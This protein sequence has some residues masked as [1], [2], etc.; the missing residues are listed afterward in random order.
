MPLS[1]PVTLVAP[2]IW[3]YP[4]QPSKF[5]HMLYLHLRAKFDTLLTLVGFKFTSSESWASRPRFKAVRSNAIPTAKAMHA[6][7]NEAFA[8]GDREALRA[9]CTPDLHRNLAGAI[10]ARPRGIRTEWELVGYEQRWYYPRLAD[11]RV[12][13]VPRPD[14]RYRSMKQAVVSIASVQRIARYDDSPAGAGQMVPGSERL[15]HMLEHIVLQAEIDPNTYQ[16]GPW[17]IWGTIPE[18]TYE[19]Y[20]EEQ[21]NFAAST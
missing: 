4:R 1:S 14:G 8:A 2:P 15:R 7:M 13:V 9:I 5:F 11:W 20:L 19:G 18:S 3:R 10:D 6:R 17:K 16:A 21:L 12:A